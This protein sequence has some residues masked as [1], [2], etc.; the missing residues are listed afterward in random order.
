MW[1]LKTQTKDM[2]I[3]GGLLGN[4]KGTNEREEW[5]ECG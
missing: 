2:E 4:R 5:D 1:N 3:E